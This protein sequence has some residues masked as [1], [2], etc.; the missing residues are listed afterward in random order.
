MKTE[1]ILVI[2]ACGQI[3]TE[4]TLQLRK[5]YGDSNVIAADVKEP[6]RAIKESG[7]FVLMNVMDKKV[8]ASQLKE[9]N[10]TQVYLLAAMLSATG[11]KHPQAAWELNMQGLLNILDAAKE[12][13]INKIFWPSSIAVFG[14][15]APKL[16]CP[17][18]TA[19]E[20]ETV[21]G[22]SKVAGE[23]WCSYY[24]KKYGVDVRSIRYPGLIS[25]LAAPGGGTTDYAI[26]IFHAALTEGKYN[27]FL[28]EDTLLPMMYMP[29]AIR[30]TM[31][32]METSSNQLSIRTSYNVAAMSFTPMQLAEEIEK[33]VP[34]FFISYS[35]DYRQQIAD[36]WPGSID[37]SIARKD[38]EW[39]PAYNL[40]KMTKDMIK[41]LSIRKALETEMKFQQMLTGNL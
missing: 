33:H 22:T 19:L 30:A 25:Y 21:Y 18:H 34:A 10:V 27:C 2:G 4:L 12:G 31:E 28:K 9:Q 15:N 20:P 40:S 38:W 7:P 1:K 37:D 8:V 29:D 32:L 36:S 11:E 24:F 14:P 26:D 3:G 39:R 16:N 23:L 41:Q 6:I 17:Q 5:T 13:S 35:P